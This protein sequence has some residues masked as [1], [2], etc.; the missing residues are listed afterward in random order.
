MN[1]RL[2]NDVALM[3]TAHLMK[4]VMVPEDCRKEVVKD[5][6][7]ICRFGL[8]AYELQ[9]DRMQQRLQPSKN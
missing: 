6:Y 3:M 8:E 5:F 1:Q 2:I 9:V 4:M 7:D